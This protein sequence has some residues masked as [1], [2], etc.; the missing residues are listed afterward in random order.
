MA[1]GRGGKAAVSDPRALSCVGRPTLFRA[2]RAPPKLTLRSHAHSD[3]HMMFC[4]THNNIALRDVL[5][6]SFCTRAR[7]RADL[8]QCQL[9]SV[10]T[11]LAGRALYKSTYL[12]ASCSRSPANQPTCARKGQSRSP[13]SPQRDGLACIILHPL[14]HAHLEL[15]IVSNMPCAPVL[16]LLCGAVHLWSKLCPACRCRN[17]GSFSCLSLMPRRTTDTDPATSS[18]VQYIGTQHGI[19]SKNNVVHVQPTPRNWFV[20]LWKRQRRKGKVW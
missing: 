4:S 7:P 1:A 2:T 9:S 16:N 11:D 13:N 19:G 15:W 17:L 10:L 20:Q 18:V 3:R 6:S 12:Y 5:Q 8:H 14:P